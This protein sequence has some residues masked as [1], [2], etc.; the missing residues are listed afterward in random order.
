MTLADVQHTFSVRK[1][2]KTGH[3]TDIGSFGSDTLHLCG[4]YSS[5]LALLHRLVPSQCL[6][7]L[8]I[9]LRGRFKEYQI[10][11]VNRLGTKKSRLDS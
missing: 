7:G 5:N 10:D 4:L 11:F 3:E 2:F 8:I 1:Y 6:L 9:I